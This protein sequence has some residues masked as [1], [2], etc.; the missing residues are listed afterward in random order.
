MIFWIC[1]GRHQ[2]GFGELL[3][4]GTSQLTVWHPFWNGSHFLLCLILTFSTKTVES[5]RH[6]TANAIAWAA[7]EALGHHGEM[8]FANA[9][10]QTDDTGRDVCAPRRRESL[11]KIDEHR[12]RR[13]RVTKILGALSLRGHFILGYY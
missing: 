2:H 12:T 9:D 10:Q 13:S 3:H 6:A 1:P 8:I 4:E 11:T 7:V 5:E